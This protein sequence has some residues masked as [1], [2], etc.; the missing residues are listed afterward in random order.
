MAKRIETMSAKELFELAQRKEAEEREN[1]AQQVKTEIEALRNERRELNSKYKKELSTIDRKI[2][3]L[4]QSAGT[5]VRGGRGLRQQ[6]VSERV[7][8]LV[9]KH[10]PIS[11]KELRNKLESGGADTRNL[12]QT[13][14][15]LKAR[16]VVDTPER[17][18][19]NI[20]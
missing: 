3:S 14:A 7:V 8:T 1:A 2:R 10:G 19:Y 12:G 13:L 6:G 9:R 5:A 15:Y 18:V 4:S 11:L 20:A 16:G 17:A